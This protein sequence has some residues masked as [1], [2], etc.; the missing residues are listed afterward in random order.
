MK[1]L[2]K[3]FCSPDNLEI[4][5]GEKSDQP[6]SYAMQIFQGPNDERHAFHP[7]FSTSSEVVF[8]KEQALEQLRQ[9][10]KNAQIIGEDVLFGTHKKEDHGKIFLKA[11]INPDELSREQYTTEVFCVLQDEDVEKILSSIESEGIASTYLWHDHWQGRFPG[12]KKPTVPT[13]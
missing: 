6:G 4:M 13:E 9:V 3:I 12:Y 1:S 8:T 11:F 10:L 5:L 7:I 2:V